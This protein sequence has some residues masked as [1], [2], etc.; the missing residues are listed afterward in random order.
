MD[1]KKKMDV[2]ILAHIKLK[3]KKKYTHCSLIRSRRATYTNQWHYL[4]IL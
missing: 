2:K 1:K 4:E 3:K